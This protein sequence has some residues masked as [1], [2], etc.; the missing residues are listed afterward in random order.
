MRYI[1]FLIIG[2]SLIILLSGCQFELVS[3]DSLIQSPLSNEEKLQ[4]KRIITDFLSAEEALTVPANMENPT[5]YLVDDFDG[6]GQNEIL[7]FYHS[8]NNASYEQNLMILKEDP[9]EPNSWRIAQ[10]ITES[11]RKID[12]FETI[13][14]DNDG[15]KELLFGV[16]SGYDEYNYLHCY[17]LKDGGGWEK[18][19]R[20]QY[21]LLTIS[22]TRSEYFLIIAINDNINTPISSQINVYRLNEEDMSEQYQLTIDNGSCRDIIFGRFSHQQPGIG[23]VMDYHEYCTAILLLKE[24][25]GYSIVLEEPLAFD[26]SAE[27]NIDIFRDINSDGVIELCYLQPPANDESGGHTT[28]DYLKVWYQWQDDAGLQAVQAVFNNSSEGYEFYL[29]IEWLDQIE[30][31][32]SRKQGADWID[33]Y[34][35]RSDSAERIELFSMASIDSYTWESID[36]Q[37]KDQMI[38]LGNNPNKRRIYAAVLNELPEDI[39]ITASQLIAC[40][41]IDGGK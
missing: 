41:R 17:Q 14:W 38:V 24:D 36:Q 16:V 6:D 37:Q 12:C 8:T 19:W 10:R 2:A 34:L 7:F 3:P 21:N 15:R 1:K 26:Y 9:D 23:L 18:Q 25:D 5:A 30:Y 4:Q 40:L 20:L 33:F 35:K 28:T 39:E 31:G 11:G 22:Q 13:D 32:F 27:T 29:P